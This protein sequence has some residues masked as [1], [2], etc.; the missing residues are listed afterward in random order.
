MK[1]KKLLFIGILYF[2]LLFI[3]Y[4]LS[5]TEEP[6]HIVILHANDTH[7]QLLPDENGIGGIARVATL[8]K[9]TRRNNEGRMIALHAGDDF[10]RGD[11]LTNFYLG[12]VNMLAMQSAGYDVFVPGNGDF[13]FGVKNL[14]AQTS[15]VKF[16]TIL[17]NVYYK[18][19]GKRIFE[20]YVIKEVAGVKIAILGLGFIRTEHPSGWFLELRDPIQTAKQFIPNLCKES[21]LVIALTHIGLSDD[22]K[23]AREVSEIDIIIGGHSHDKLNKPLRISK[24]DGKGEVIIVQA[25]DY[26]QYLG[27]LDLYLQKD[28]NNKY[29]LLK[30][31]GK[32]IPIDSS[33]KE[34]DEVA[35]LLKHYSEALKEV[36]YVSKES[37]PNPEFGKNPMGE[38]VT[39]IIQN[40]LGTDLV[41]LDRSAVQNGINKGKLTAGDIYKIH[42]WNNRVLKIS[43]TGKQLKDFFA[44]RD[45]LISGCEYT[46]IEDKITSL[47]I[48]S[49]EADDQSFY[50]VAIDDFLYSQD[51]NINVVSFTETGETVSS[52][53]MKYFKQDVKR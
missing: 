53:L 15:L 47:K 27:R 28:D 31:E 7:G 52:I 10:S 35:K 39:E 6:I 51:P 21:D 48:K 25:G 1:L 37:L 30:T 12:Q 29:K 41:L 34:D 42:P 43:L 14:I 20:P 36:I 18:D 2:I 19:N 38:F 11:E 17:A 50:E 23:L 32:L 5:W 16:P 24:K 46:K 45:V 4:C 3:I 44:K 9:E 8:I 33:I 13:Y 49:K 26:G 40:W 22:K